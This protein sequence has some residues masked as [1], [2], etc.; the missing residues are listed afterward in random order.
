MDAEAERLRAVNANLLSK[1]K[2]SEGR[3]VQTAGTHIQ[4][5][6]DLKRINEKLGELTRRLT[7]DPIAP[8]AQTT[9]IG[10]ASDAE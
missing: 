7:G 1:W 8:T 4:A 6:A 2:A 9:T 3:H 10:G 5:I